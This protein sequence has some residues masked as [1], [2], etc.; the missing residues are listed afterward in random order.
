[1]RFKTLTSKTQRNI[2]IDQRLKIWENYITEPYD[3]SNR[4]QNV[5]VQPEEEVD[6]DEKGP[7]VLQSELGKAIKETRDKMTA[8]DDDVLGRYSKCW[9]QTVSE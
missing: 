3:R 4:P 1:M 6:A 8:G 9:E 5:D 2:R 7:C